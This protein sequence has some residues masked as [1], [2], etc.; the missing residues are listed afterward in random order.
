MPSIGRALAVVAGAAQ[1]AQ[2]RSIV[3]AAVRLGLN[4]VDLRC[5]CD[6]ASLDK[7]DATGRF[8]GQHLLA[9]L[10]PCRAIAALVAALAAV[11]P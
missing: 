2:V 8:F 6:D 3:G 7:T 10:V 5:R 1:G 4:M 11:M 9:Q